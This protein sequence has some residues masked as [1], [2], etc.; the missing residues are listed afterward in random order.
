MSI[1]NKNSDKFGNRCP[2]PD[3]LYQSNLLLH[4]DFLADAH[5]T[6]GVCGKIL[7]PAGRNIHLSLSINLNTIK[8]LCLWRVEGAQHPSNIAHPLG[9]GVGRRHR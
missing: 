8:G 4:C 5:K 1:G 3:S 6:S 7:C 9:E 2:E